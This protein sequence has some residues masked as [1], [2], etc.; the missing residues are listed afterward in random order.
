M[1]SE[2]R[3]PSYQQLFFE[4][5]PDFGKLK[6]DWTPWQQSA[7]TTSLCA[8]AIAGLSVDCTLYPLDTLRARLQ[9][10]GGFAAAGGCRSLYRG[11]GVALVGSAPCSALFFSTFEAVQVPLSSVMASSPNCVASQVS[12]N[13]VAAIIGELTA[14][15]VRVPTEM[16]KQRL[17]T[18]TTHAH[19]NI[20][21][22][23]KATLLRDLP[24]STIQYPL[25]NVVKKW[26]GHTTERPLDPWKAALCG[27]ATSAIAAALTTPFDLAQTRLMLGQSSCSNPR[28]VTGMLYRIHQNEGV[29]GL[30]AGII[31]RTI[32][33]GIGG[34][35]F[36]GSY[37]QAKVILQGSH[38]DGVIREEGMSMVAASRL[39]AAETAATAP[40]TQ[41]IGACRETAGH[42]ALLAGGVA[43]MAV[44]GVL[45]PIDTLKARSMMS[46]PLHF[47]GLWQGLGAALLPAIPANAAFFCTYEVMKASLEKNKLFDLGE[48]GGVQVPA[49]SCVAAAMAEIAACLIR[50]PSEGVKMRLQARQDANFLGAFRSIYAQGGVSALYRGLH[51][52]ILLDV[53]F[54]LIQFPTYETVKM[55][56]SCNRAQRGQAPLSTAVEGAVSGAIAGAAAGLIT[57]PLD[58]VRTQ[59]VLSPLSRESLSSSL[60]ETALAIG[61]T[62][63]VSGLFKGYLPRTI[64]TCLGGA[65][66]LGTYSACADALGKLLQ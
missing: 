66:Y 29:T 9:A 39:A 56:I 3:Q 20:L 62:E 51:A 40:S 49:C 26:F 10:P 19:G 18:H 63:G 44:D 64:Y 33:M 41:S 1:V 61:S 32:W 5:L 57:T 65:V 43:G 45:H 34:L 24:F 13:A 48:G 14:S 25:Y 47:G 42:V 52:T 37:E 55:T 15:F 30:F 6:I 31:P 7:F 60:L 22:C 35:I 58:V 54:A 38:P 50:V 27:S 46:G 12:T 17:Q 21:A 23:W 4:G 28:S 8:G 36:L 53:P 2:L 11:I 16:F 59:H